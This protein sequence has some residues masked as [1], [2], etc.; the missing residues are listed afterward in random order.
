MVEQVQVLRLF[1][2][3]SGRSCFECVYWDMTVSD[4]APPAP[5][6]HVSDMIP[7]KRCAFL[8]LPVAWSGERHPSPARQL[9]FCL[10]GEVR[11]VPTRGLPHYV[12]PG[13]VWLMEDV[14]GDGHETEVVSPVPFDAAVVQLA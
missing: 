14:A 6:L 2:D 10:K 13:D 1:T 12:G 8:R 5:P 7:A 9:L 11:V 3:A 4:F